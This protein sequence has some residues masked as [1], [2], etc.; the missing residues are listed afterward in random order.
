MKDQI[1]ILKEQN[2]LEEK[3]IHEINESL[4]HHSMMVKSLE[5][6]T[7]ELSDVTRLLNEELTDK[8]K[9]IHVLRSRLNKSKT[10]A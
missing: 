8:E 7:S 10:P 5:D 1:K 4:T 9:L 2:E 6:T 3:K